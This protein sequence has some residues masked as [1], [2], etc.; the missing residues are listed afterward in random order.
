MSTSGLDEV[1]CRFFCFVLFIF[2]II[3]EQCCTAAIEDQICNN[4]IKLAQEKN[5]CKI[6]F[7]NGNPSETQLSKMCYDCCVLG[8]TAASQGLDCELQGVGLKSALLNQPLGDIHLCSWTLT[9]MFSFVSLLFPVS[10]CAQLSLGNGTCGCCD[11][12]RLQNDGVNCEDINECLTHRHNCCSSEVCINTNGSFRCQRKIRCGTGYELM[13][14]NSCKDINECA[15]GTH[16]CGPD[17]LCKNTEGSFRCYPKKRCADGFIQDA[18]GDCIDIN[19]CLVYDS[20]CKRSQTCINTVGSY[21]CRGSTVTCGRGYHLNEDGTRCQDVNECHT[22]NVCGTHGCVNLMGTYR[23]ECRTGFI[24]NTITKLCEDINECRHYPGRLCTHK[25]E[26]TQGSYRCSC[27]I[28]F[29]LSSDGRTCDE[30]YTNICDADVDECKANLCSQECTNIYGSYQCYCRRGYRLSDIDGTT[31]EDI[32]ECAVGNHTCS[33]SESC[34][35]VKGGFRCLSLKCPAN[36]RKA[37]LGVRC[38]KAC[39]PYDIACVRDP[40]NIITHTFLSLPTLRRLREPEEIAFL[41]TSVAANPSPL[42]G[43]TYVS[44]DILGSDDNLSFDVV[45]NFNQGMTVGVVRQVKP[46]IG[47]LDLDLE[48]SVD[49]IKSRIIFRRNIVIIH[50]FISE[51]RM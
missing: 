22:G 51:F 40:V 2:R 42:P 44:F 21:V 38:V 39:Q 29:K 37:T 17:F 20:P 43:A 16:D 36:Y 50:I 18:S 7:H 13:D 4:S 3:Q 23:C 28:G 34:I 14:D 35:N 10:I 9:V 8:L 26:N 27:P 41:R 31:C 32:D 5:S 25:C 15:L 12:Y 49:Y 45:K 1:L 33:V 11:G 6:I 47:P 19:E 46:I 48:I 24:L 30:C